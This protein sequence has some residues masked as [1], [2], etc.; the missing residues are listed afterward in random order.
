MTTS[1]AAAVPA[2]VL[3][4]PHLAA[5]VGGWDTWDLLDHTLVHQDHQDRMGQDPSPEDRT[6]QAGDLEGRILVPVAQED[7]AAA[8]SGRA[9]QTAGLRDLVGSLVQADREGIAVPSD[10][11]GRMVGDLVPEV[12][13]DHASEAYSPAEVAY[14]DVGA[15]FPGLEDLAGAEVR[16][17]R[18]RV[19]VEAL[20]GEALRH[21]GREVGQ[22]LERGRAEDQS[23]LGFQTFPQL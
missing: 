20:A 12:P 19:V 21:Q 18:P 4:A 22:A 9:G 3:L 16:E 14:P 23:A 15:A 11:E 7:T 1:C 8:P 10:R 13:R 17:V 6:Q 5:G 2:P